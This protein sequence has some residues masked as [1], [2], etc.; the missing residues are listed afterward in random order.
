MPYQIEWGTDGIR[1]IMSG[2]L[3]QKDIFEADD[4]VWKNKKS[5]KAKYIIWDASN[6]DS[7]GLDSNGISLMA[8]KEFWLYPDLATVCMLIGAVC[9]GSSTIS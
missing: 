1:M 9:E 3:S 4:E 2:H 8:T 6:I 5:K 7:I